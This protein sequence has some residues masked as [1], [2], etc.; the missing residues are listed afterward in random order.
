[1]S[2]RLRGWKARLKIDKF[3]VTVELDFA[4]NSDEFVEESFSN[5]VPC[6]AGNTFVARRIT[7]CH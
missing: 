4:L 5:Y 3:K 6:F 1:M 7:L 2:G